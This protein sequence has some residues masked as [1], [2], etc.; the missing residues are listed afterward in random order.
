MAWKE[1]PLKRSYACNPELLTFLRDSKGLTQQQLAEIAGYSERLISKAEAGQPIS[2]GTIDDLAEALSTEDE[3]IYPEDLITDPVKHAK[4]YIAA[5]YTRGKG[6]V[7]AIAHFLDDDLVFR[8]AGDPEQLPFAGEHHGIDGVRRMF[9]I[10]FSMLEAPKNHNHEEHYTFIGQGNEVSMVGES[11][12]HPIGL[13]MEKPIMITHRF[14]FRRGK[15]VL[16][17]D[18][19]DT[20][21]GKKSFEG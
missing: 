20:M 10:F 18:V 17:E 3:P 2:I 21:S 1:P 7:D 9:D 8:V 4:E 12:I 6:V 19:F 5:V 13:P 11:W 14:V 15:L 16:L